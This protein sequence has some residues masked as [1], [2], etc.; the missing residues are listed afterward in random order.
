MEKLKV[1]EQGDFPERLLKF[2]THQKPNLVIF[3]YQVGKTYH[4]SERISSHPPKMKQHSTRR[5]VAL[6]SLLDFFAIC[7][8]TPDTTQ[9]NTWLVLMASHRI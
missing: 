2:L 7:I 4:C 9:H 1:K 8:L 5:D 6:H 3:P